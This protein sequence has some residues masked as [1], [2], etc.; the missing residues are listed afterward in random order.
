MILDIVGCFRDLISWGCFRILD[1]V[2]LF[3]GTWYRGVVLR[4]MIS[5]GFFRVLDI[6][7]LF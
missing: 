6:V 2:G 3:Q 1:I 5:W 4:Y 7:G